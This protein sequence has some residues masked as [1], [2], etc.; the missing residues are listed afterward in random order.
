MAENANQHFVPQ[1]YFRLFNGGKQQTSLLLTDSGKIIPCAPIKGQC[2]RHMFYGSVEIERA[3]SQIE[4]IQCTALRALIEAAE[5]NDTRK[6][7]AE[8]IP[9][10]LQAVT[11]QRSRTLL[12]V[13]KHSDASCAMVLKMFR[14]HL[15][16]EYPPEEG[17]EMVK[18]IDNGEVI[19]TES[20]TSS[21]LRQIDVGL[22][23][24][25]LLSDLTMVVLR[26]RT[27]LPFIFSDS[28]VVFYNSYYRR[29]SERGVLGMQTPGLQVFFPL[30]SRLQLMLID[31]EPYRGPFKSGAFWDVE[32]PRDVTQLN[33]LQLCHSGRA[34]YFAGEDHATYVHSLFETLKGKLRP[35]N[36][37]FRVRTDYA[38]DGKK[39][40]EEVCHTF[41]KQINHELELS[42]IGCVPLAPQ[43][44][45]FRHRDPELVANYDRQPP[46]ETFDDF[47][48][49]SPHR[50]RPNI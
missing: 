41:E 39:T 19:V 17:G 38:I 12:E 22:D 3:F 31:E 9:L 15:K 14:E 8:Q 21:V 28:P 46:S 33:A 30:N 27:N 35:P 43:L 2:A 11:F 16:H 40:G 49:V 20:P 10:L 18:A 45:T 47:S 32:S 44:Y 34:V 26:N 42:F 48:L 25:V 24:A 37:E 36:S 6:L 13:E 23:S 50:L 1:F 4:T 29:I 7:S 5:A